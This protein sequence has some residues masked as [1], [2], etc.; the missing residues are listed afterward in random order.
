M[1]VLKTNKIQIGQSGTSTNNFVLEVP[2]APD[3]TVA[4]RRGIPGATTQDIISIASNGSLSFNRSIR[5]T[6]VVVA[7]SNIDL[8]EGTYFTK[9]IS[10][11]TTFTVSN[12]ASSGTVSSFILD[13]TN[14][15]SAVITWWSGMKWANGTSPSLTSSGRDVLGFFT[16][17]GGTT[18][19]GLFLGK[20]VK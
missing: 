12:V 8:A 17:D 4:L 14:G 5:E 1:S 2:A 10:G 3:G 7:A 19:T 6:R 13:L 16:H 9:T 15:G 11:A 20:D 18:W